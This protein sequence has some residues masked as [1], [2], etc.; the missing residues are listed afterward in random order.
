MKNSINV[1]ADSNTGDNPRLTDKQSSVYFAFLIR[2]KRNPNGREPYRFLYMKDINKSALAKELNIS[3]P[4]LN[5]AIQKLETM[6]LLSFSADNKICWMPDNPLFSWIPI[7][8]LQRLYKLI[9]NPYCGGDLIRLYADIYY[10]RDLKQE[11][12]ASTWVE[13][14]GLSP[15]ETENYL[16]FHILLYVLKLYGFIDYTIKPVRAVGGKQ[17]YLYTDVRVLDADDYIELDETEA[18]LSCIINDYKK[19]HSLF[20]DCFKTGFPL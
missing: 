20:E 3:R 8:T 7:I 14:F 11:F 5:A 18:P 15:R 9:S 17:Y 6:N 4:T 19:S 13:V 2:S 12:G 1:R 10:T 16:K